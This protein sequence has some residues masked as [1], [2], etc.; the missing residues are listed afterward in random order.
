MEVPCQS[1][2]LRANTRASV[3]NRWTLL[4]YHGWREVATKGRQTVR[5]EGS[6]RLLLSQLGIN[7][8]IDSGNL[9]TQ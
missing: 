8:G 5:A 7:L 4:A 3:S 6:L 9:F 1:L 2:E